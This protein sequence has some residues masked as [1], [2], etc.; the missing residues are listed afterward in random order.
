MLSV[1]RVLGGRRSPRRIETT[2]LGGL[3][4][5]QLAGLRGP[6]A[7]ALGSPAGRKYADCCWI[8]GVAGRPA[9]ARS[10]RAASAEAHR[11][12]AGAAV[13]QACRWAGQ[14]GVSSCRARNPRRCRSSSTTWT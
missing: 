9:S 3:S 8:K 7:E 14:R 2:R 4:A 5:V 10:R 12:Q 6:R 13:Y 11:L 1:V